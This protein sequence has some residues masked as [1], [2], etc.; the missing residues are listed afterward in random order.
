MLGWTLDTPVEQLPDRIVTRK[1]WEA[2][3]KRFSGSTTVEFRSPSGNVWADKTGRKHVTFH[4]L[5]IGATALALAASGAF[6]QNSRPAPLHAWAPVPVKA[7]PFT[8]P[9]KPLKKMTDI[10][11]R[12]TH[13]SDWTENEVRTRDYVGDYISMGP[14]RKT[15]TIFWA[16]DRVFLVGVWGPDESDY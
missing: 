9:N 12:H 11:A 14:G 1:F 6:A 10:L 4:K 5:L 7:A 8:E 13:E 3:S 16:D 15:K 2:S